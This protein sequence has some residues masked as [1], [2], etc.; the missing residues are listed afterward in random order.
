LKN[1]PRLFDIWGRNWLRNA[2]RRLFLFCQK[3][4]GQL[5]TLPIRHLRP[6]HYSKRQKE[7]GDFFQSFA[8]F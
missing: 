3:L 6:W 2:A 8:P 4:G 5:P 7:L 1:I